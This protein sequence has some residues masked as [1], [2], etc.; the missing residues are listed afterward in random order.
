MMIT[1]H[2]I[3]ARAELPKS[4]AIPTSANTIAP[5]GFM[6]VGATEANIQPIAPPRP[7]PMKSVGAKIPPDPPHPSVNAVAAIFAKDASATI[8]RI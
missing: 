6:I 3:G 8:V 5:V 7:P 2:V 1:I 4:D